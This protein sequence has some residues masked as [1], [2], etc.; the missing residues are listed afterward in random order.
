[1]TE[2]LLHSSKDR[3]SAINLDNYYDAY[4]LVAGY[5]VFLDEIAGD[6]AR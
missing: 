6:P 4:K 1:V 3:L 2:N 5:L